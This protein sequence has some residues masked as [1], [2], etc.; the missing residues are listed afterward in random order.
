MT[1]ESHLKMKEEQKSKALFLDRDG[2]INQDREYPFTPQQIEFFP[3]VFDLCTTAIEKGY[4]IVVVTNQAGVAK[5]YFTEK[6]VASLHEWMSSQFRQRGIAIARFYYCPFHKNGTVEAYARE[7]F[8][9]KPKPGMFLNAAKDL[10][11]DL[12]RSVMIGDKLSDRIELPELRCYIIKSRYVIDNYDFE[13]L[14][15]AKTIL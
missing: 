14:E 11:I 5:G 3:A 6:D 1:G 4:I 15:E 2:V 7:S 12:S 13:T 9:R 10:N 8:C